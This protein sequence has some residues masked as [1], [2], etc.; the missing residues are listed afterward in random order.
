MKRGFSAADVLT[1]LRVPLA[2][3]FPFVTDA[4][5]RLAIVGAVAASDFFD[6][7]L[8][9]RFGATRVG[10]LLDPIA[11]KL[12]AAV[13]F[14]TVA[15]DTVLH[16]LEILGVLLRDIIAVLAF[17]GTWLRGRPVALPARAGGKWVTVLQL[18]TLTAWIAAS[19]FLRP[20]AWATTAVSCYA[21][22][23]YAQAA[24]KGKA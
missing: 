3:L 13:A 7:M 15:R 4:G 11:D 22:W 6:G 9:R 12:F 19:P 17:L 20:L 21:L 2:V 16:P 10:A 5:G 24:R 18:M 1:A 8:A 23:D 14:V